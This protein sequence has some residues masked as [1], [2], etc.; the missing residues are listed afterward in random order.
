MAFR[1]RDWHE[2]SYISV[3]KIYFV[4]IYFVSLSKYIEKNGVGKIRQ[5]KNIGGLTNTPKTIGTVQIDSKN[6][7]E[8]SA[9]FKS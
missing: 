7:W 2:T 1:H 3:A 5:T 6:Y 4:Y 9:L 8:W